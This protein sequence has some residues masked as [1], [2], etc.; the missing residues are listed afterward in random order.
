MYSGACYPNQAAT[1]LD[2]ALMERGDFAA[3]KGMVEH[4]AESDCKALR[5]AG[6]ERFVMRTSVSRKADGTYQSEAG[7]ADL[8]VS[9]VER[10]Y[11]D[12]VRHWQVDNEPSEMWNQAGYGPAQYQYFMRRV[13]ALVRGR[14]P[15]DV[16][17]IS[18]PLSFSPARWNISKDNPL[19]TLNDWL[20]AY[21]ARWSGEPLYRSFDMVGAN[22]YW[23]YSHLMYD[24]SYGGS[25][26]QMHERSGGMRVVV[27]EYGSSLHLLTPRPTPAAIEAARAADYPAYI[28]YLRSFSY[29]DSAHLFILSGTPDWV[30]FVP[31]GGVLDALHQV[32]G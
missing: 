32:G 4:M 1:P 10:F 3:V 5:K 26:V 14:V 7:Y 18:P 24:P 15:Q 19:Y 31:S 11:C 6:V 23:Q 21:A 9:E 27:C 30:G 8:I 20:A 2:V 22:C 12:G 13:M 17:F 29:V 25:F 28:T 16:T